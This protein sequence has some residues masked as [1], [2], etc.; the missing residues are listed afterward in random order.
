M[1]D[2]SISPFSNLWWN[3]KSKM[4]VLEYILLKITQNK[5]T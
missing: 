4:N 2:P 3:H 1:H 5:V